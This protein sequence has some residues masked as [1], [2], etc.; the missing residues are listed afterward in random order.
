[1]AELPRGG[2]KQLA[3]QLGISSSYLSRLTSGDRAITA[4]RCLQIEEA[5]GGAVTR[6]DLRPDL[7]WSQPKKAKGSNSTKLG[8]TLNQTIRP[9]PTHQQVVHSTGHKSSGQTGCRL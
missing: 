5:T 3:L 9:Q 1:M 7:P 6:F 4:E 2:R 8:A